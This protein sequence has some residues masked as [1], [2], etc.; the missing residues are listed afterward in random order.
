M[1]ISLAIRIAYV[2]N[3]EDLR[4]SVAL[5]ARAIEQYRAR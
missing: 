3:E 2:L 1:Q 4:T 5:L